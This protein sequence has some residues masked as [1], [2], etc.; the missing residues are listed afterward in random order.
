LIQECYSSYNEHTLNLAY[1]LELFINYQN[2][3]KIAKNINM[4]KFI[5]MLKNKELCNSNDPSV[6]L[7]KFSDLFYANTKIVFIKYDY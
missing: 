7:R 1:K 6:Y 2:Y 3:G 4:N 5:L